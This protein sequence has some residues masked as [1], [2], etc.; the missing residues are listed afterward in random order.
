MSVSVDKGRC[1]PCCSVEPS[2][3]TR[4]APSRAR[5]PTSVDVK[6]ARSAPITSVARE[7]QS[8]QGI[9]LTRTVGTAARQGQR[10]DTRAMRV[11]EG[12]TWRRPRSDPGKG[13]LAM[14]FDALRVRAVQ[15]QA[16]EELCRHAAATA[17]VVGRARPAGAIGLGPA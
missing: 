4:T 6:A 9:L 15:W 2:G 3:T 8:G 16:G 1:G 5:S 13:N 17:C 11:V 12:R 7:G 14:T 10:N